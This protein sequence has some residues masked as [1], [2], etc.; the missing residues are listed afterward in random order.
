MSRREI[1][2]CRRR[3]KIMQFDEKSTSTGTALNFHKGIHSRSTGDVEI[4]A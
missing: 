4:A 1:A 2:E 3:L